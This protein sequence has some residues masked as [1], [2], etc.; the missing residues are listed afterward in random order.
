MKKK[1]LCSGCSFTAGIPPIY[2]NWTKFLDYPTANVARGSIG[3][4]LAIHYI[5]LW[6]KKH[7][8]PQRIIFQ[9][10]HPARMPININDVNPEHHRITNESVWTSLKEGNIFQKHNLIKNKNKYL[11]CQR[12]YLDDFICYCN[13]NNIKYKLLIYICDKN[14]Y[15]NE[16]SNE[17]WDEILQRNDIIFRNDFIQ[18]PF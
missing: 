9:V 11:D 16:F 2:L 10:P 17:W 4:L 18:Q 8:I 13:N 12:Q 14:D 7:Y 6:I 5:H 15:L 3:I 1:M